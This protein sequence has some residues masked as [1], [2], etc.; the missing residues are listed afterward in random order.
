MAYDPQ[1]ELLAEYFLRRLDLGFDTASARQ[2]LAQ[3]IQDTVEA[4]L[5]GLERGLEDSQ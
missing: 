2:S 3:A 4:F 5:N 1:C